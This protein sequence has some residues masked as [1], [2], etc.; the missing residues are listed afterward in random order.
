[1]TLASDTKVPMLS[2]EF[3]ALACSR[4]RSMGEE[5]PHSTDSSERLSDNPGLLPVLDNVDMMYTQEIRPYLLAKSR[6]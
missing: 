2:R 3:V 1:M 4:V 5:V 6:Y